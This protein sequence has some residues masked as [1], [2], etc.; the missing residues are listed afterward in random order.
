M[1][2]SVAVRSTVNLVEL[3]NRWKVASGREENTEKTLAETR[4]EKGRI[5]VEARKAFPAKGPKSAG[6]G[7]LLTKWCVKEETALRYMKLAGHV[8]A[9]VSGKKPD[10]D[11]KIP[12]YAKAGIVKRPVLRVVP[13]PEDDEE[14]DI[15]EEIEPEHYKSAFLLRADQAIRFGSYSGPVGK[16]V[17][18][19][20]W[21]VAR[22]WEKLAQKMEKDL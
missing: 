16:E 4:L 22:H 15:E 10:T 7:E 11:D 3:Y 18:S 1:K 9:E 13:D 5:L 17:V 19:W 6:W 14:D 8:D 12:T 21:R 20:A 2:N